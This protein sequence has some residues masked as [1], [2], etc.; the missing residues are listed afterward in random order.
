MLFGPGCRICLFKRQGLLGQGGL[1]GQEQKC[2]CHAVLRNSINGQ[3][4]I[5]RALQR[6]TH[7]CIAAHS[8]QCHHCIATH[9][10]TQSESAWPSVGLRI[11]AAVCCGVLQCIRVLQCV[12]C[13]QCVCKLQHS[14]VRSRLF[15]RAST[16]L[17][18][19]CCCRVRSRNL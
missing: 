4:L 6:Q 8:T 19:G 13:V 18:L 10:S 17:G 15:G 12:Q 16:L 5:Y 11:H 1:K 3:E 2:N 7:Q 14:H 9:C